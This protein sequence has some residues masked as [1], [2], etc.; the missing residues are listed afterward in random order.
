MKP[1]RGPILLD[2][3]VSAGLIAYDSWAWIIKR[4]ALHDTAGGDHRW[5][6]LMFRGVR[7]LR[8]RALPTDELVAIAGNVP[9]GWW[10]LEL[11][12]SESDYLFGSFTKPPANMQHK[13]FLVTDGNHTALELIATELSCRAQPGPLHADISSLVGSRDELLR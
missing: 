13:H 1:I 10:A 9:V 5:G 8:S 6:I 7:C 4:R 12:E 2:P 3:N 11:E